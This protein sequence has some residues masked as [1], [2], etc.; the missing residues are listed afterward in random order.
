M[1]ATKSTFQG[2]EMNADV[3]RVTSP[4]GQTLVFIVRANFSPDKTTFVTPDET[5]LQMGFIVYPEGHEIAKHVHKP[6]ERRTRG[7][8][9][10]VFIRRGRC[11]VDLYDDSRQLVTSR[12][13]RTGDVMLTVSGGHGFRMLD[14]TVIL[15][16]KQGPYAGMDDK[17]RF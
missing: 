7:T 17:E 3:E 5:N 10:A 8:N 11:Q 6:I 1:P 2:H 16:V 15:E 12:E 13:L 9:E 4:N 14:D